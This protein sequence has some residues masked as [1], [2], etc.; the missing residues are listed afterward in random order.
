MKRL[1]ILLM[2]LVTL[3]G[4]ESNVFESIADDS[5]DA[6]TFEDA[7]M[8]LDDGNYQ[9][10]ID[11]LE[12][13]YDSNNPDPAVAGI[14]ASAYMG[15][16]GVDLTYLIEN[17]DDDDKESFDVIASALSLQT[18][19]E[20]DARYL[21]TASVNNLLTNLEKA[22]GFLDD[23]A[24]AATLPLKD[25]QDAQVQRGIGSAIH[26]IMSIGKTAQDATGATQGIPINKD[27]YQAI[28]ADG[29]GQ[30]PATL[31]GAVDLT[32]LNADINDVQDAV[33][34]LAD[35]N[36][37]EDK[38]DEFIQEIAGADGEISGSELSDYITYH[39]LTD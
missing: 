27:A 35:D 31:D 1:C 14:L 30:D 12:G 7:R 13:S 22:N 19:A 34:V 11:L 10:A 17:S 25:R 29:S 38:L 28:Y 32:A 16:A 15:K 37:I 2:A 6:A 23:V 24:G 5:S 18:T 36:D 26:F 4:C 20:G 9:E 3:A 39:L 8:A 33:T 21:D